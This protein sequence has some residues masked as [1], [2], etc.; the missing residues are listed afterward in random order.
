MKIKSKKTIKLTE[1]DF[2]V[3]GNGRMAYFVEFDV[4]EDWVSSTVSLYSENKVEPIV[5]D[6][7]YLDGDYPI[8]FVD[9][10]SCFEYIDLLTIEY[11]NN[12]S[13]ISVDH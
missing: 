5:G 9:P 1:R 4:Y 10:T 13:Y 8:T 3:L 7:F 2:V 12:R 11:D 6:R